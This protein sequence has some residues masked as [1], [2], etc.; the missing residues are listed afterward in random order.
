M[1]K[2]KEIVLKEIECPR[3]HKVTTRKTKNIQ[4]KKCS[5]EGYGKRFDLP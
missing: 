4:C 3:G 2:V 5:E 1:T